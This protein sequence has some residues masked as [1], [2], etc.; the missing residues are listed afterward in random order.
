MSDID[1][2]GFAD[3]VIKNNYSGEYYFNFLEGS[4]V[5]YNKKLVDILS[6]FKEIIIEIPIMYRIIKNMIKIFEKNEK[7]LITQNKEITIAKRVL[8]YLTK[9]NKNNTNSN[10]YNVYKNFINNFKKIFK[11]KD[12]RLKIN[13]KDGFLITKIYD[14]LNAVKNLIYSY[15]DNFILLKQQLQDLCK[16]SKSLTSSELSNLIKKL[17]ETEGIIEL[18]LMKLENIHSQIKFNFVNNSYEHGKVHKKESLS[19]GGGTKISSENL[20]S[21][22]LKRNV[23]VESATSD[24]HRDNLEMATIQQTQAVSSFNETKN[25][26]TT[27]NNLSK[28]L[29]YEYM[30]FCMKEEEKIINKPK[31]I[32][33]IRSISGNKIIKNESIHFLDGYDISI[34]LTKNGFYI[35][36]IIDNSIIFHFSFHFKKYDSKNHSTIHYK[37]NRNEVPSS[38]VQM[39]NGSINLKNKGNTSVIDIDF[40]NAKQIILIILNLISKEKIHE[41][42]Q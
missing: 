30:K 32:D 31:L 14:F 20:K 25:N 33:F 38:L 26:F 13:R 5:S 8:S 6:D 34:N 3:L 15:K 11:N 23:S 40:F 9:A 1:Q 4:Q 2:N 10:K 42:F 29:K 35:N 37:K 12:N 16:P 24:N 39:K 7:S 41:Y 21:A 18:F 19:S 28:F 22:K 17:D 36:F 27:I